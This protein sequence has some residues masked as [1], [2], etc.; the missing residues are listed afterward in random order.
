MTFSK[1]NSNATDYK[2]FLTSQLAVSDVIHLN[3]LSFYAVYVP[4]CVLVILCILSPD[5]VVVWGQGLYTN[6]Y[7]YKIVSST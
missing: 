7:V 3:S 6:M 2:V 5:L 1:F 4:I